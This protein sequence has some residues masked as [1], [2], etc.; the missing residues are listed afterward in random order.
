MNLFVDISVW[1][2]ALRRDT[3]PT[4]PEVGFLQQALEAGAAIFTTGVVLQELLQGFS[5]PRARDTLLARFG[6]LPF[7]VPDRDDHIGAADLHNACRRRGI[8]VGTIDALLAHLCLR[9]DF[10]MLSTDEDFRR[11]AGVRPLAVWAP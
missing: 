7:V 11:I 3:P 4:G 6:T 2:L 1:S 8:K 5:G 10:V 9:H